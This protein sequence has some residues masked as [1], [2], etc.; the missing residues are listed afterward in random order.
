[1]KSLHMYSTCQAE[2]TLSIGPFHLHFHDYLNFSFEN[3]ENKYY[4]YLFSHVNI[5]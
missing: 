5:I 2:S 3:K 1:M 4:M